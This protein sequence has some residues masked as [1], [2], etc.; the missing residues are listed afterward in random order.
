MPEQN[1]KAKK[2]TKEKST[3]ASAVSSGPVKL[4]D[5]I[6]AER[7]VEESKDLFQS[8]K[9]GQAEEYAERAEEAKKHAEETQEAVIKLIKQLQRNIEA[10]ERQ[11]DYDVSEAKDYL[12]RARQSVLDMKYKK[13]LDLLKQSRNS[14]RKALYLPFPLLD[15]DVR[16][17]ITIGRT[18]KDMT[19]ECWIDNR[20][21]EPLGDILIDPVVPEGFKDLPEK[22]LGVIKPNETRAVKINLLPESAKDMEEGSLAKLLYDR[23]IMLRTTLDCSESKPKYTV[24]IESIKYTGLKNVKVSPP[25]PASLVPVEEVKT[26]D[27]IPPFSS[28]SVEFTLIP[29]DRGIAGV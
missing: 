7:L 24:M 17:R 12:Q 20:M 3:G 2:S 26:I 6:E 4:K 1:S 9:Y 10:R 13:A 27:K 22:F 16:M 28:K 5:L 19:Y 29:K 14:L 25:V 8:G 11:D 23:A 18:G 15:K 21:D